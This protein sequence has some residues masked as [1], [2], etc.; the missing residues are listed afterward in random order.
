MT[1][2]PWYNTNSLSQPKQADR[3]QG[4]TFIRPTSKFIEDF[5]MDCETSETGSHANTEPFI[6]DNVD[7][8]NYTRGSV[9]LWMISSI[10]SFSAVSEMISETNNTNNNAADAG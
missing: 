6:R 5:I 9:F 4:L 7:E 3:W 10:L 2:F 8:S 1:H